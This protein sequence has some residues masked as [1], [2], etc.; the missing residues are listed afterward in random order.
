[1]KHY[2]RIQNMI[3]WEKCIVSRGFAAIGVFD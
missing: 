3:K 1:M 2:M